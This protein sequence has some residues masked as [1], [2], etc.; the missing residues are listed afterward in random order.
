MKNCISCD[1]C[2]EI[3]FDC[4]PDYIKHLRKA[5]NLRTNLKCGILL[6]NKLT[7][8]NSVNTYT[9]LKKHMKNCF[10]VNVNKA[11]AANENHLNDILDIPFTQ[12]NNEENVLV[13]LINISNE[14]VDAHCTNEIYII[15]Y[16]FRTMLLRKNKICLLMLPPF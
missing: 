9:G 12:A 13:I 16:L 4:I 1:K 2:N 11:A 6:Q 7:C 5:H 10:G 14:I 15:S 8:G 3:T